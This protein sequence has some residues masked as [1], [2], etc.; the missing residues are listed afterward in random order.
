MTA[1]GERSGIIRSQPAGAE[2]YAPYSR[3]GWR[4]P[5]REASRVVLT[6]VEL[7]LENVH[8]KVK[9]Y[10]GKPPALMG[11][12]ARY[13]TDDKKGDR[14]DNYAYQFTGSR[15][16]E[17][18]ITI[19]DD[20]FVAFASDGLANAPRSGGPAGFEI[21][22]SFEST[23]C[24]EASC[25]THG[26]C[27]E[28][29][30]VCEPG[31][32]GDTCAFD[33][34]LSEALLGSTAAGRV[35]S[36]AKQDYPPATRCVWSFELPANPRGVALRFDRFDLEGPSGGTITTDK[37]VAYLVPDASKPCP[38]PL[39]VRGTQA[40]VSFAPLAFKLFYAAR[41]NAV[42]RR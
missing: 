30:C 9:I 13:S 17:A 24:P 8:D 14:R 35:V 27:V 40:L 29:K 36:G 11:W 4:V 12:S 37:L 23:L 21:H 1:G 18:P 20:V 2:A 42:L 16:P 6:F 41:Q 10:R 34:C 26:R 25:G 3:C 19:E 33:H 5:R 7:G 15:L 39:T 38:V 28:G 32:Y 31:Y 22:W